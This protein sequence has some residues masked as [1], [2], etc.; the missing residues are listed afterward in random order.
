MFEV[1]HGVQRTL[2]QLS[3]QGLRFEGMRA[4]VKQSIEFYPR[5]S[6]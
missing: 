3:R 2:D 4:L 1:K 5:L 6:Q